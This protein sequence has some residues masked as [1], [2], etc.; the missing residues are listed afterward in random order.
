MGNN[1]IEIIQEYKY[2]EVV[3]SSTGSFVNTRKHITEQAEKVMHLLFNMRINN[4]AESSEF[5]SSSIPS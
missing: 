1:D 3:L 4:W 2:L 5:V